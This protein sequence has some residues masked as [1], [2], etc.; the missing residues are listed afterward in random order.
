MIEQALNLARLLVI[1][2]MFLGSLLFV[3][4][5][6]LQGFSPGQVLQPTDTKLL[7][8]APTGFVLFLGLY[9]LMMFMGWV[10]VIYVTDFIL[11]G[12]FRSL[13]ILI[14]PS[15][16]LHLSIFPHLSI[17]L[18]VCYLI[19]ELDLNKNTIFDKGRQKIII[20]RQLIFRKKIVER[21]LW[22]IND[23]RLTGGSMDDDGTISYQIGA[24]FSD[25][26]IIELD[27]SY[28]G[29]IEIEQQTAV[30]RIKD[31]LFQPQ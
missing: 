18:L 23:I 2:C 6:F 4:G 29:G 25:G 24:I 30:K 15:I 11:P 22:E 27:S 1:G 8:K 12:L 5:F 21:S 3:L 14:N 31:F 13:G 19:S 9:L 17:F 28:T 20:T 16:F 7:Y 10:G 26:T